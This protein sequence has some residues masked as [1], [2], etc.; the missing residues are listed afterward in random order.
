MYSVMIVDDE[1]LVRL[2]LKSMVEW[3]QLGFEI[4]GEAGNGQAAYEKF[5]VVKPDIVITDIRM[6]KKDGLWLTGKIKEEYPETE[7]IILTCYDE[8]NYVR[9]ALKLQVSD[10]ILKAEMEEEDIKAIMLDKKALLDKRSRPAAAVK[11]VP[12]GRGGALLG[13]LLN[14]KHPLNMVYELMDEMQLKYHCKN[15]CFALFDFSG[16]LDSEKYSQEQAAHVIAVCTELIESRMEDLRENCFLKQLGKSIVL[17]IMDEELS[18]MKMH[19]LV[20]YIGE[21]AEQYFSVK[22]KTAATPVMESVVKSREYVEWLYDAA[23]YMFYIRPGENLT[24]ENYDGKQ[25]LQI[26]S[27]KELFRKISACILSGDRGG[28]RTRLAKLLGQMRQGQKNAFDFKLHM[29]RLVND[30]SEELGVYMQDDEKAND[31]QQRIMQKDDFSQIQDLLAEYLDFA[32]SRIVK[33]RVENS[34]VLIRKA[35]AY[36]EDHY[37]EKITLDGIAGVIGIS[38]YYFSTLFKQAAGTNFSTYLNEIR[39][40]KARELLRDTSMTV[41]QVYDQVG[42]NDQQYF[43]KTF[44]KYTGMTVTEYR[45]QF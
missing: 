1:M 24:P 38:R 26:H 34:D 13:M 15:S 33:A 20:E 10:Y 3:E 18:D 44:K 7:I 23:S 31:F 29:A 30:V 22:L 40:K 21:S 45:E 28:A 42:F 12:D 35:Q 11:K 25:Q 6:P 2:G 14:L 17:F 16:G 19:R 9:Q 37:R 39:I 27:D 43:C 4:V 5:L 36:M 41:A 8:F 32:E